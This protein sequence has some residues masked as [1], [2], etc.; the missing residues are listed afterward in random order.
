MPVI[1]CVK[2]HENPQG[3]SF[4]QECGSRLVTTSANPVDPAPPELGKTQDALDA[5]QHENAQL[6]KQIDLLRVELD[7]FKDLHTKVQAAESQA[8]ALQ[9][10]LVSL[11]ERGKAAEATAAAAEARAAAAETKAAAAAAQLATTAKELEQ[12]SSRTSPPARKGRGAVV[13]GGLIVASLAAFGGYGLGRRLPESVRDPVIV[14]API[15]TPSPSNGA[16]AALEEQ[17]QELVKQRED[18]QTKQQAELKALTEQTAKLNA[19]AKELDQQKAEWNAKQQL[20]LKETNRQAQDLGRRAQ[21]VDAERA[22]QAGADRGRE[23]GGRSAEAGATNSLAPG[24]VVWR[25]QV[26]QQTTISVFKVNGI[27]SSSLAGAQV[28]GSL[29][30]RPCT[31]EQKAFGEDRFNVSAK[32]SAQNG[33]NQ[34]VFTVRGSKKSGAWVTVVL[35]CLPTN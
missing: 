9:P 17:K 4:C 16:A 7:S 2:G 23:P 24:I 10:Q 32:P 20:E 26:D 14:P 35:V 30:G 15:V 3:R 34:A 12:R 33:W 11:S 28:S 1:K 27:L 6:K 13:I 5:A 21:E 31:L 18:W 22:R 29:T 8:A 25:G 19:R